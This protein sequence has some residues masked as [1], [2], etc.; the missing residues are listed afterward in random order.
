MRRP[1]KRR[2]P[3]ER[4]N[5]GGADLPAD[6]GAGGGTPP[7]PRPARR[8]RAAKQNRAAREPAPSR[9]EPDGSPEFLPPEIHDGEID[10][11]AVGIPGL[12]ME[13]VEESPFPAASEAAL[14]AEIVEPEA[15]GAPAGVGDGRTRALAPVDPLSRYLAEIR[16]YPSLD[17]EEEVR[18]ARVFRETGDRE[19][20]A[21]LITANLAIVVKIARLFRHAVTNALDLIQE[22]NLGLLQALDRFDPGVGV[23]FSTYAGWWVK[24]YILKYLLDNVRMVRVGTTN[25]R[26]RLLYNL[27]R[28]KRRLDAAGFA[29]G[30]KLLAEHFGATERDVIEIEQTLA[31]GDVSL[32]APVQEDS[33]ATRGDF[34]AS[35]GPS[36]EEEVAASELRTLLDEKIARFREGLNE[37]ETALLDARLLADEPATLQEIGDRFGI[38]REAVRQAEKRLT[39]RLKSYLAEELGEQAIL[40]I[41]TRS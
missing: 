22:G 20:A 36:V 16:R 31:G 38:T 18:L 12:A 27:Q 2:K 7:P 40:H 6:A 15:L 19:A 13:G 32:D 35:R 24:A 25:A 14:E 39:G 30:P 34:I 17:R 10:V 33:G 11:E 5:G 26:R 23:R 28:E 8:A 37:R 29:P 41:R 1:V 21:R 9:V 4:K 3:A